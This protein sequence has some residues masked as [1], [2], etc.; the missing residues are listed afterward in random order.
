MCKFSINRLKAKSDR[1]TYWQAQI[2]PD[3]ACPGVH[4]IGAARSVRTASRNTGVRYLDQAT[5]GSARGS[6]IFTATTQATHRKTK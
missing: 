1:L 3:I 6:V 4:K 2:R 5:L